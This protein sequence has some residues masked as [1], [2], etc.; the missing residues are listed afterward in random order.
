MGVWRLLRSQHL[1]RVDRT[2]GEEMRSL[3]ARDLGLEVFCRSDLGAATATN[4]QQARS[5]A[6]GEFK[7]AAPKAFLS[8]ASLTSPLKSGGCGLGNPK[9]QRSPTQEFD[10]ESTDEGPDPYDDMVE[11]ELE[12]SNRE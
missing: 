3:T 11:W 7:H 6:G 9:Q 12:R 1:W 4:S 8:E 10:E 2:R 5:N